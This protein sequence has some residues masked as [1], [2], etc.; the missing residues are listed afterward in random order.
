MIYIMLFIGSVFISSASQILLKRSADVKYESKIQEYLN[1][2][3][4]IAYGI[5]FSASLI[6]IIAYRGVPLSLGPVLEA[7]GYVFVTILGR[8]FLHEKVSRRK[9]LGLV[10]ILTGIMVF[11][12]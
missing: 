9:L 4:I 2:R 5:F 11:N 7:S 10:L 6:T 1:P 8:I 3:V 12:L